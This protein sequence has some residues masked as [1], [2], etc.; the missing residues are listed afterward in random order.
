MSKMV[1][2]T[3]YPLRNQRVEQE[4]TNTKKEG[5]QRK[6]QLAEA[7]EARKQQQDTGIRKATN[8]PVSGA[9]EPL[10]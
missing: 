4:N 6:K 10:H 1:T 2:C 7:V 8:K 9:G 5:E 3:P